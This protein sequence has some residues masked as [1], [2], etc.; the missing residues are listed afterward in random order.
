[1]GTVFALDSLIERLENT[2]KL[3]KYMYERL[4]GDLLFQ[5]ALENQ[6]Y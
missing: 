6:Y 5:F 2:S 4:H 3:N 1:M